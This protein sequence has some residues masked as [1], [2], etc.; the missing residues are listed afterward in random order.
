M[1]TI[2]IDKNTRIRIVVP[3]INFFYLRMVKLKLEPIELRLATE[4]GGDDDSVRL[5]VC[6]AD[7][8]CRYR[9]DRESAERL[10]SEARSLAGEQCEKGIELEGNIDERFEKKI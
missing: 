4:I 8:S 5:E 10:L 2:A 1:Q 7:G 6:Y 3:I 9:F